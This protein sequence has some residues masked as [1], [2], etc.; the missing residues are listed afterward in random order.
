MHEDDIAEARVMIE[1]LLTAVF[2]LAEVLDAAPDRR[3][4]YRLADLEDNVQLLA[5]E[6]ESFLREQEEGLVAD[7]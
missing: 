4:D 2:G 3:F 5:E 7:G 1:D 6:F